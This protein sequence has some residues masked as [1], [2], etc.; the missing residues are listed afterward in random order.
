[1]ADHAATAELNNWDKGTVANKVK[2]IYCL[3]DGRVEVHEL[4]SL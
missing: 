4:T 1:M 3:E 2:N